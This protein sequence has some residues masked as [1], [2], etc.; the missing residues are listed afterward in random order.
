MLLVANIDKLGVLTY[1]A[2]KLID[3]SINTRALIRN[4]TLLAF[5]SSMLLT[6]DVAILSLMPIYLTITK[7]VPDMNHKLTGA[8]LLII[9]ANLG[10]SFFPF[11]NPQN[12]FLFSYYSLAAGT[13]FNW[14]FLLLLVSFV[15]LF[16]SFFWIKKS[17]IPNQEEP[18]PSIDQRNIIYLSLIGL[19]ILIGVFDLLPYSIVIP[20]AILLLGIYDSSSLKKVDYRLLA[21]FIFF[22]I[23]VGNFSQLETI[24]LLIKKQFTTSSATFFGSIAVSQVIS[25]VPAAILIA[26][27]TAQT[28]ALFFGVNVG[29][30][31]TIIASLANLIGFKIY[32]QYYPNQSKQFLLMFS[33]INLIFLIGFIV[34]FY[35]IL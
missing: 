32:K 27:F 4:I 13:F 35:F 18:L 31:G 5:F 14:A 28:K 9:A 6:N 26:P 7:K 33:L 20:I 8:V 3:V 11:G 2:E 17:P 15:F 25:N 10:S 30:L 22:F 12:L 23:A 29:G 19:L 16:L 34:L 24:S 21:T 1:L